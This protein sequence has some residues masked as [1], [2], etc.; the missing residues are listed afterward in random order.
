[1]SIRELNLLPDERRQALTRQLVI[2]SV[3]HFLRSIVAS[4]VIM[5]T[6]GVFAV[7]VLRSWAAASSRETTQMLEEQV[8]KYQALRGEIAVQNE[9]LKFMSELTSNRVVWAPLFTDVLRALPPGTKIQQ[10]GA[11]VGIESRL[12]FTGQAVARSALVV[13]EERLKELA[14]AQSVRA[15]HANLL[16]RTNPQFTFDVT[17]RSSAEGETK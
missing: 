12:S 10:L 16:E 6:V 5:T 4:L 1:M 11:D 13:I 3:N 14:W 7:V 2:N 9:N 15:P 8:E 17:L